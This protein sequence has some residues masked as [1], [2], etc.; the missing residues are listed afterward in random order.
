MNVPARIAR[1]ERLYRDVVYYYGPA[2]PW[3][4]ALAVKLLG[5]R[6]LVLEFV[7]LLAAV[8]LLVSLYRLTER[9]GSPLSACLAATWAAGLCL[10]APKGGSFLF[11]YSFGAL[12]ALAGSFLCLALASEE[13]S[14]LRDGLA[15]AGLALALTA[16]PEVGAAAGLVLLAALLRSRERGSEIR[17]TLRIVGVASAAAVAVYGVAF[18]GLAFG[19]LFPEGPLALFSPPAEW[20]NVYRLISGMA[21]PASA[22]DAIGTALFLDVAILATAAFVAGRGGRARGR[23]REIV[24]TAAVI[25]LAGF[26]SFGAGAAIEDRLPPLLSP[27]PIVALLAAL[28]CLRLPLEDGRRAQFLLFAF[29]A[30]FSSRVIFGLAYGARTTPYSVLAFPGLAATASVLS[31]DLLARRLPNPEA[32]RRLLALVFAALSFLAVARWK[33]FEPPGPAAVLETPAG[34]LRLPAEKAA[35]VAETLRLL[36]SRARPGDGLCG[37]P[38]AGFFNFVTGLDNPLR[39]EQV[40]PGHLDAADE[41]RV[42]ERIGRRRPRFVLLVNQPTAPFGP[43]SFGRDYARGI[44]REVE[45]QYRLAASFANGPPDAPV[46]SPGFFIRVYERRAGR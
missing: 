43:V 1:G 6:F 30:A 33:R 22:F 7:G 38:E 23:G 42:V 11:P 12:F 19:D 28:F 14:R 25:A 5:R 10:G 27:L 32:A 46:G 41:A 29:S 36:S 35:A 20:R 45:L 13:P 8:V 9:A 2:G 15:A 34:A 44:W 16:K 18:A 31:L 17:R 24:W 3:I 26:L 37:F 4:N 39:E 40:Y 21:D